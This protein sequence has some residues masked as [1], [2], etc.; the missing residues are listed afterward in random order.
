MAQ[1]ISNNPLIMLITRS[2][3]T[4]FFVLQLLIVSFF[5]GAAAAAGASAPAPARG[6]AAGPA[7]LEAIAGGGEYKT[8][9]NGGRRAL[10]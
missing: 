5:A 9:S 7:P 3:Y 10:R 2:M 4:S 8:K 6:A 1:A